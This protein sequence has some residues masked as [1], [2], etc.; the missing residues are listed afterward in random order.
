MVVNQAFFNTLIVLFDY[1]PHRSAEVAKRLLEE[2]KGFLQVDGYASYNIL[3]K[4]IELIRIGCNMHGRR[5]FEKAF[6]TGAK[7]GTTLAEVGLKFYKQL[8]DHE[9]IIRPRP[10]EERYRLRSEVQVP[11]WEEF[12]IWVDAN[13]A[14]VPPKSKIGEAFKYFR[15]EYKYLI[16]Y[17]QDGRLEMDN[18][19]AER[20]I[21]K[22][23]I[24]RNNWMF[25]DTEAGA[26]ASA[27]FYSLLCTAK[28]N[29]VNIFEA[30]KYLFTEIPKA[31]TIED[32]ERLADVI[33]GIRQPT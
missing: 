19:F 13:Y 5:Y 11:I 2:F 29:D 30:M 8:Y 16:G 3:E 23:A 32:Y 21:R 31:K 17:L 25:A 22:F 7:S 4:Q 18:G 10:P 20:A 27:M 24:G 6:K 28:V 12:K 14:K 33:M 1:D 9:E 26:H 15:S